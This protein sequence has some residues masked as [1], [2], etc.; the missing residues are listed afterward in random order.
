LGLGLAAG[1]AAGAAVAVAAGGS[2]SS[3]PS[4]PPPPA[5]AISTIRLFNC[6]DSCRAYLNG[7]LVS[8][9]GLG[10]D[11]GLFDITN[12]LVDGPNEIVFELINARGG[13]AYGFQVRRGEAIVFQEACG[14]ALRA[15]CE[16]DR[17]FP[18]GV[19]RTFVYQ[20]DNRP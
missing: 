18:P 5:R 10:Q 11:S 20:L 13:I 1:A 12:R 2:D 4:A 16:D 9:V 3:P 7:A 15:G 6:D 14:I 19:V 17:R 8:E